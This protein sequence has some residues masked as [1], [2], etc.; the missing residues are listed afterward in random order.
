MEDTTA[1]IALDSHIISKAVSKQQRG[2]SAGQF[3]AYKNVTH[4][5]LNGHSIVA[6][7]DVS[8]APN[9]EVLYLYD[10]QLAQLSELSRL[11]HLSH[12]Y[13]QNN[14]LTSL[15]GLEGL[16]RLQKLY[17]SRNCI[18]VGAR[19]AALLLCLAVVHRRMLASLHK[20]TLCSCC[21][22]A[23]T[24]YLQADRATYTSSNHSMTTSCQ[25]PLAP[26]SWIKH[27]HLHGPATSTHAHHSISPASTPGIKPACVAAVVLKHPHPQ[28]SPLPS[29]PHHHP[30]RCSTPCTPCQA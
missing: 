10:N 14:Q 16:T 21:C 28:P 15:A 27:P 5:H 1:G 20:A 12:L 11:H 30:S 2:P 18:Q 17:A 22:L 4:L 29:L 7:K 26:A 9:V 19:N 3:K 23:S 24:R 8:T 6:I 25:L 13:L